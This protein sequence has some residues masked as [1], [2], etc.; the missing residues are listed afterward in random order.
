M[1]LLDAKIL[2][3][4]V[5]PDEHGLIVQ[6]QISDAPQQSDGES[7]LPAS[8]AISLTLAV[9]VQGDGRVPLAQI[10]WTAI[11]DADSVLQKFLREL[12]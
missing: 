10:Q 4:I 3:T 9:R 6:L 7:Q 2:Q 5:T 8:S 12:K 1:A 11:N